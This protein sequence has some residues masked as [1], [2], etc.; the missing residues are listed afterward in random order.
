MAPMIES[1]RVVGLGKVGELVALL[2][3]ETG[4]KVT[5][6][7]ARPRIDLPFESLTVDV[8]D[9]VALAGALA[10]ADAV[11]S[12]MPYHLNLGVAEAA[13]A[14]GLHYFD[15]TEDVPT[16]H[17]IREIASDAQTVFAPQCG[18]APGL[19]GIVGASLT[20]HFTEIRSIELKVGA[21][22][23]HPAGLLGYAFNWSAEGVVNEYLN[24]C[25]VLRNGARQMVPAMTEHERVVI[26]GIELEASLTSGGLGTMCET[27]EGR[28]QR[29]DYK[30]L[31][32]PGHFEL[33]RFFFDELGLRERRDLAGE[34]L[35]NA[36]PPVDDDVVYLHAAVE[37]IA[38]GVGDTA[39]GQLTRKQYVRAYQPIALNGRNWR[40][41]SWTTAACAAAVIELVAAGRLASR[42][43]IK[44][45]SIALADVLSTANGAR[46]AE[47]GRV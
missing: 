11:I 18:L 12:A 45:E 15:L 3:H 13:Y 2:L 47:L 36:K 21:L 46:F 37:G 25:E 42:G 28:V 19:I 26:G 14:G 41:I 27:L 1:V 31:R 10:G 32:Y 35:V 30:T 40:A 4:F 23:R 34:I 38:N 8:R 44:Q 5:A 9:E 43:F 7:D 39:A 16:M 22:P 33:M 29:L 17:H 6:L 20:H 24:D